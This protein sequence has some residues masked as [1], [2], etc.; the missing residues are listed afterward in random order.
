MPTHDYSLRPQNTTDH[1]FLQYLYASTRASEMSGCGWPPEVIAEFLRQQF[2][3]QLNYFQ[4]HFPDGEFWLIERKGQAIG[5]LYLLWGKTTLQLIDIALLPD[6]RG[7]GVGTELL[8]EVLTR[9]D[10]RGLAV[11]LHVEAHN[12]ALR[13]YQ[14]LGFGIIDDKGIYLEMQRPARI[15]STTPLTESQQTA[16]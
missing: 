7:A 10:D 9:A 8:G 12:R 3:L 6:Q 4:E 11:G 16:Y 1:A 2:Q 13:L 15:P 5:R 14:R